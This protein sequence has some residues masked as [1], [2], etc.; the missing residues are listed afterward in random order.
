MCMFFVMYYFDITY[1]DVWPVDLLLT[2]ICGMY[3]MCTAFFSASSW[4]LMEYKYNPFFLRFFLNIF[5]TVDRVW[6]SKFNATTDG[7]DRAQILSKETL[8]EKATERLPALWTGETTYWKSLIDNMQLNSISIPCNT[9]KSWINHRY[10]KVLHQD[11]KRVEIAVN[12]IFL[13]VAIVCSDRSSLPAELTAKYLQH[14]VTLI[15]ILTGGLFL[16]AFAL[17]PR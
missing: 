4:N 8:G 11:D 15:R 3:S 10:L 9:V 7:E 17:I 6:I 14:S 5:S 12:S 13:C 16:D 1:L 2:A